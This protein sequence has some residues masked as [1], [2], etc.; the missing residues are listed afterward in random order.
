VDCLEGP[1]S[2][3]RSRTGERHSPDFAVL[4]ALEGRLQQ[5]QRRILEQT[6]LDQLLEERQGLSQPQP[7][8][9]I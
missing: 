2:V 8:F 9:F 7:M 4:E 6:R 1:P 3:S 5:A